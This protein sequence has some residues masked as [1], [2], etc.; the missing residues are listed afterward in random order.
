MK[1]YLTSICC[2][3]IASFIL[4]A[5]IKDS[6]SNPTNRQVK[7]DDPLFKKQIDPIVIK[8]PDQPPSPIQ[9]PVQPPQ[10]PVQKSEQL[11]F[12]PKKQDL[13]EKKDSKPPLATENDALQ[14]AVNDLHTIDPYHYPFLRY[15]WVSSGEFE[16]LQATVF[17][18]NNVSRSTTI[19]R[20]FPLINGR[21]IVLRLD[22]RQIAP[23]DEDLKEYIQI[24]EDYQFVPR[25]STLITKDTLKFALGLGVDV[26]KNKKEIKKVKDKVGMDPPVIKG[27]DGKVIPIK[28]VGEEYTTVLGKGEDVDRFVSLHTNLDLVA[29]LVQ[30]TTSQVPIMDHSYFIVRALTTIEDKGAFKSIYGG[31]HYRLNGIKASKID[32]ATDEDIFFETLGVGNVKDKVSAKQIFDK[33]R[34]DSRVAVFRSNVTGRPRRV[35]IFRTLGGHVAADQSVISVTHDIRRASIDIGVHPLMNLIDFQDDAREVIFERANGLLGYVLFNGA[36]KLQVSVPDD[37]ASDHT[38]PVPNGSVLQPAISCLRCHKGDGGWQALT[39]DVEKLVGNRFDIFDDLTK[40]KKNSQSDNIDRLVGLYA[41]RPETKLLPRA[42]DDYASGI[43]RATGPWRESKL[44]QTDIVRIASDRVSKIFKEYVYDLVTPKIVLRD[45]GIEIDA[46]G[47]DDKQVEKEATEILDKLLPPIPDIGLGINGII[48]DDPRIIA[49]K[50]GIPIVRTDYDLI[51]SYLAI[52]VSKT[53]LELQ[54]LQKK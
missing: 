21:L 24:F 2:I 3:G 25:F 17:A 10:I 12:P 8:K 52:R 34:S 19:V 47:K 39:N 30:A 29:E 4:F 33:L 50:I 31:L 6:H 13:P 9:P 7:P 22:L 45:L 54:K 38:I 5:S 15:I 18:I 49:L 36:G 23:K 26:S 27:K 32:G 42:R 43:L 11:K 35:D 40:A 53:R 41:G 46:T 1:R 16:D 37:V 28:S 20:P 48:E 14:M 44:N 51:Y